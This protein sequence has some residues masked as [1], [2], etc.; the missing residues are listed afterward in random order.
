MM[1]KHRML[2]VRLFRAVL[3]PA[4]VACCLASCTEFI[5]QVDRQEDW[6]VKKSG[7]IVLYHRPPGHGSAPSPDNQQVQFILNN[8]NTYYGAIQD[9]LDIDFNDRV[10]IYLY[11]EDEAD[12]LIGTSS[13][14]HSIPKYNTFYYTFMTSVKEMTDNFGIEN[15][16]IGAHELVHVITHRALGYPGTRLMSEGYAVWLDGTYGGY[17]VDSI[18]VKYREEEP[19]KIMSPDQLLQESIT[20]ES[21]Y[22]PNCG[23]L[24]RFLVHRYGVEKI[25]QL[26]TTGRKNFKEQFNELTATSW[27]EMSRE[28]GSFIQQ[29]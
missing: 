16:V 12:D 20:R 11:N 10:L 28:Y 27:S 1:T 17:A 2:P 22:Y 5:S 9:S 4:L 7:D 23:L 8:Q 14:G 29:L 13:G 18:I 6:R 25:N 19:A 21:V 26:F 3:L 24:T 15:P